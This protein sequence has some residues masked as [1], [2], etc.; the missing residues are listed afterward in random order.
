MVSSWVVLLATAVVL[1]ACTPGPHGDD[2]PA[3]GRDAPVPSAPP[4]QGAEAS[5]EEPVAEAEPDPQ[6]RGVP[7]L[8]PAIDDLDET[9]VTIDTGGER[10]E[11]VAKVAEAPEE[12]RRGLMEVPALP[13]GVG[14]LFLFD[15]ER[16]GGFW[17]WNTIIELDIAFI[18]ADGEAHTL[19]T[20]VP[21]EAERSTDCA[22]TTP[23]EPYRAALEV[24]GGWFDR[25]GV[26]PGS[27]VTWAEPRPAVDP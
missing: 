5:G 25:A 9:V 20:M 13:E 16:T 12:R 21:C 3:A 19:A 17:M 8:H 2:D 1:A 4:S 14:M 7:P 15:A 26:A 22:V 27:D 18:S 23:A 10:L 11:V 24:S 6:A